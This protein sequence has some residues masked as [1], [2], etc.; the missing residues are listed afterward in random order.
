MDKLPSSV[1]S[2]FSGNANSAQ[3]QSTD[4]MQSGQLEQEKRESGGAEGGLMDT[5]SSK[6]SSVT[7]SLGGGQKEGEGALEKGM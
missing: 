6:I 5:I 1:S 2:P 7:G 3:D 4:T